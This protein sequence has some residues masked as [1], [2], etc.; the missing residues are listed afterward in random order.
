MSVLIKGMAMPKNCGLCRF[1]G[2]CGVHTYEEWPDLE[3][4]ITNDVIGADG[5]RD[6]DCPLVEVKTP[7]GRLIDGDEIA[8]EC[9]EPNCW[10][11]WRSAIE[12]APIIIEA[13]E[14]AGNG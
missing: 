12:D 13:E 6:N 10:C 5:V 8:G 14:G 1:A 3:S 9:D 2:V 7:H 11:R 4:I